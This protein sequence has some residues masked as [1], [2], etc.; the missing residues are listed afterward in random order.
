MPA[1][2]ELVR[3]IQACGVGPGALAFWWLGQQGFI[4]KAGPRVIALDLF[5][6]PLPGRQVPPLVAP[7]ELA[8]LDL[9]CGSHD[10]ADHIDRSAWPA[11]AAASPAARFVVPELLRPALARDLG[12]DPARFLG[13]DDG[14]TAEFGGVRVTGIAAAHER[15]S[16]DPRTGRHP[17]LGFVVEANGCALYHAGDTCLYEGLETKLRRWRFDAAF[18]PINGRDARRLAAGCLGNLTYQE[19][20]DL[21]GAL[22]P[23]LVVPAHYDMFADNAGDVQA[24]VDYLRVKY[25]DV[26]ARV[27]VP[28]EVVRLPAAPAK[29]SIFPLPSAGRAL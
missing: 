8:G 3:E 4:V 18:L 21:A 6:S 16:P 29:T 10:H 23:R 15:L 20:V 22:R 25:P 28:G 2:R 1:H 7:E 9:I 12:L 27:C 26:P 5:L 19:A 11:L 14:V 17:F 13:L 24:F